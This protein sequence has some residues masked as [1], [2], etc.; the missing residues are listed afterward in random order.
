MSAYSAAPKCSQNGALFGECHNMF[1]MH[2]N[3]HVYSTM[4]HGTR[5]VCM[6]TCAWV[7]RNHYRMNKKTACFSGYLLVI[8]YSPYYVLYLCLCLCLCLC[9]SLSLSPSTSFSLHLI[10]F[11]FFLHRVP[12]PLSL[13]SLSN[14]PPCSSLSLSLSLE[15]GMEPGWAPG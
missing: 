10:P 8:H 7:Q 13:S 5:Q 9:L 1:V 6:I 14:H 3:W 15:P 11:P 2:Y 4:N 12:L